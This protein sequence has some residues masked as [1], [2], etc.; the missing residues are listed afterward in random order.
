MA[1]KFARALGA[2]VALFTTSP[3]KEAAA[4]ELG[5]DDVIISRDDDAMRAQGGR[6]DFILDTASAGH[7]P[8]PY[9]NALRLHG[10]LC[11]LGIADRIDVASFSLR[12]GRHSLAGSG[13]GSPSTTRQMLDFCARNS[14]TADVEVLPA[15]QVQTALDRLARNDVRYRFV[16]DMSAL[17]APGSPAS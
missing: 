17:P 13:T 11:M 7:D 16:L 5:A 2:E 6:F 10:T 14:L 9:L 12:W 15:H 4:R 1:V 3:G 8:S